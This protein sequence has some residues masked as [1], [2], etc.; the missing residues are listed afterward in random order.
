MENNPL[1][2]VLQL[3]YQIITIPHGSGNTS[4]MCAFLQSF[5]KAQNYTIKIDTH[6]NILAFKEGER[7]KICFQSHYDM[8]CV[9]M[10]AKKFP[11]KL[12]ENKI[13]N[14]NIMQTWLNAQDSSL[15]ADNGMGLAIMLYCMKN[16]MNAEFLFTNNEEI[17]M[18]GAKNLEIPI[19]SKILLNL[20]SEV[21]GEITISCAGGY[22]LA[23]T[24][25]FE[26]EKVLPNQY[27][28]VLQS[29]NFAG[30]HSGI[31]IGNSAPNYRN[32]IL[33]S[34]K[35][36][37]N[38]LQQYIIK[39]SISIINWQGGE[40]RNSIPT[41][42]KI[43]FASEQKLN[44]QPNEFFTISELENINN[45]R[46]KQVNEAFLQPPQGL[47]F[48]ILYEFLQNIKIGVLQR[49]NNDMIQNSRNLSH[50]SFANGILSLSFMGRANTKSLLDENLVTLKES[51][52]QSLPKQKI[53]STIIE[54][55]EYYAPWEK[56]Q[57]FDYQT[58]YKYSEKYLSAYSQD[59]IKSGNTENI[60]NFMHT[61]SIL[62]QS[63]AVHTQAF[64]ITPKI[65]ELHA[66]LE[67]GILLAKFRE[68][69]LDDIVSLSIGPTIQF[70]HS[71][72]ERVWIESVGV[73]ISIL[74]DFVAR[75]YD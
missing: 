39:P 8:V 69:G 52:Q 36:L 57:D 16:Q 28:Y 56:Q 64:H 71:T 13:Q 37:Y 46:I 11:P 34:A 50:I 47:N 65:V 43:I 75:I 31:D 66:G 27:Y 55:S 22:D 74:Q 58:F 68:M 73:V 35:F 44:F 20:D 51:L 24:T 33:E 17:G 6:G 9:G 63:M 38:G 62:Y 67:C 23:Y 72:K 7:P 12:L 3:F 15:G 1:Q 53:E 10:V 14:G 70:P 32:A 21:L 40:K 26:V 25:H 60:T 41:N 4:E 48:N 2:D 30:G 49:D 59:Y 45:R 61:L 18:I 42:S 19:Q 29:H 5:I 54:S